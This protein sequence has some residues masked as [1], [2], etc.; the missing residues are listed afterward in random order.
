MADASIDR[1]IEALAAKLP[2]KAT[3]QTV[4]LALRAAIDAV[5]KSQLRDKLLLKEGRWVR[6][7]LQRLAERIENEVQDSAA[8]VEQEA[9][10]QEEVAEGVEGLAPAPGA[11]YRGID[12]SSPKDCLVHC[13]QLLHEA[14]VSVNPCARG[15]EAVQGLVS[16]LAPEAKG[17]AWQLDLT[18]LD[19]VAQMVPTAATALGV[20]GQQETPA[21]W[22]RFQGLALSAPLHAKVGAAKEDRVKEASARIGGTL[23]LLACP[24][25]ARAA[26]RI[27][28]ACCGL[29]GTAKRLARLAPVARGADVQLYIALSRSIVKNDGGA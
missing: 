16:L 22:K 8:A 13:R 7:I 19:L 1:L 21:A 26:L 6:A 25:G 24:R 20:V 4:E 9:A 15:T 17:P 14:L 23:A 3:R 18:T 12:G 11:A 2:A 28:I 29:P 5:P 27:G 10:E